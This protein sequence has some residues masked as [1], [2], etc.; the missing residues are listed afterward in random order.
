M[1]VKVV[2]SGCRSGRKYRDV[3]KRVMQLDVR[4][5]SVCLKREGP[6]KNAVVGYR[7]L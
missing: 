4:A 2:G 3:D 1:H 6:Y 5:L 7:Q